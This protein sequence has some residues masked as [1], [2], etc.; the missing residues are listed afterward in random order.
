V[1]ED[2]RG[3][4]CAVTGATRGLGRATALALA[5]RGASL[6]LLVRDRAAGDQLAEEIRR[7]YPASDVAVIELDL[8][9]LASVRRAAAELDA[10][11]PRLHVL[12]NNAGVRLH[13]RAESAEG[14]EMT[15]AVNHL[16]PFLLTRLLENAL[17]AAAPSRVV[18]V[19]SAFEHLGR[20][21]LDDLHLRGR[22]TA[23]RA[24]SR[25]K[26]ANILF[27]YALAEHL[28]ESGV[29]ANC[30][31]PGLVAT[32]LMRDLP[33]WLRA[34]YEPF[35][36]T[37]ERAARAIVHV[38]TAPELATT[39]GVYF[40]RMRPARSSGRSRDPVLRDRLWRVSEK[41]TALG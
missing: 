40:D 31:H 4:L 27:T 2:M 22:Y 33:P 15:L 7:A 16:G 34:L 32:D 36:S 10:R 19:T 14:F 9:S 30:V 38:A 41:L 18:T 1:N 39:T 11:Y 35:L 21:D 26:Q 8:A 13:R 28:R 37:P 12:V 3:R 6:A 17:R 29:T 25:S 24:Y 20:I 5:A 23:L